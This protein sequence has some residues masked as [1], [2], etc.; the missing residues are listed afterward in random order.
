VDLALGRGLPVGRIVEF[1]GPK[2]SGKTALCLSIARAVQDA[3]EDVVW[4]DAEHALVPEHLRGLDESRF[5]VNHPEHGEEATDVALAAIAGGVGLVVVDSVPALVPKAETEGTMEQIQ[6]G[7]LARL[8]TKFVRKAA[9]LV[10]RSEST[11][12]FINHERTKVG[13]VYG[14]PL[15]TPGGSALGYYASVRARVSKVEDIK[16]GAEVVGMRCR[17]KSDKNRCSP[18]V[19]EGFFDILFTGDHPGIDR[20]AGIIDAGIDTGVIINKSGHMYLA[21]G[22]QKLGYGRDSV[23]Q[24]LREDPSRA[25]DI[26]AKILETV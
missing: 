10:A 3:G 25:A 20:E 11:L 18:R 21:D 5:Y 9:P 8:V 15:Y 13:V 7:A 14:N 4:I 17:V 23:K 1:F 12:V 26:Y 24:V 19:R 2:E 16:Q 22:G 6:V